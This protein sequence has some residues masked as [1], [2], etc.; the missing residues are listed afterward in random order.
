VRPPDC[1]VKSDDHPRGNVVGKNA[2]PV[3]IYQLPGRAK[4]VA[5]GGNIVA[6]ILEDGSCVTWGMGCSGQ[7]GRSSTMTTLVDGDG[8]PDL[9]KR[10][11]MTTKMV[12]DEETGKPYEKNVFRQD[13]IMEHFL[14]PKPVIWSSSLPNIKRVVTHVSCGN[15]HTLVAARA[16]EDS[17]SRA[18]ST[19]AGAY[20]KLGHGDQRPRHEVTL[21]CQTKNRRRVLSPVSDIIMYLISSD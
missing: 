16:P 13:V 2:E 5:A 11:Y 10:F 19:G 3:H 12:K 4:F 17:S 21:V 18:Y 20:G 8:F 15:W 6:A 14:K 9:G 7:L 1:P